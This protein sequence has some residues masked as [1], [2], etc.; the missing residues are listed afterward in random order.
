MAS[1]DSFA[2][3]LPPVPA[4]S[5]EGLESSMIPLFDDALLSSLVGSSFVNPPEESTHSSPA[6]YSP[7]HAVPSPQPVEG[8]PDVTGSS[9]DELAHGRS[10]IIQK[11]PKKRLGGTNNF[12]LNSCADRRKRLRMLM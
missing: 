12:S 1:A 5:L 11:L 10:G 8:T 3:E 7:S 2:I 9:S 6:G 4:Q